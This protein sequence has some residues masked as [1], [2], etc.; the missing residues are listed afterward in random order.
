MDWE[1]STLQP[2]EERAVK[3]RSIAIKQIEKVNAKVDAPASKSYTNRALIIAALA[4][5]KSTL[6]N[7]LVSDDTKFM[8]AA[9]KELGVNIKQEKGKITVKGNGGRFGE[10]KKELFVGNAG[11]AMRFLTGAAALAGGTTTITGNDRMKRRPI[12]DLLDGLRQL[13]V[14]CNSADG[15]PPVKVSGHTLRGGTIKMK[16]NKSS[17]Y[18]TSI[19]MISP[20]AKEDV[21]ISVDGELTSKSYIDITIDVMK[22]FAVGVD[23]NNYKKF[24]VPVGAYKPCDYQIEGDASSA[25]YF[26]G[27]A[28]ITGGK[29]KVN[30][31]NPKSAQGD[32]NFP[33]VLKK[34]GCKVKT[35]KD[36]ISL[37]GGKLKGI[38][39]DMNLMPDT[40]QTLAVVALFAKGKTKIK[41]ISNL[42]IKE[43]DR[44]AALASELKKLGAKVDTK[45]DSITI[46]PAPEYNPAEIETYDDH[47]MAM[48]FSLAG[49]K[50]QGIKIKNPGCVSKSFP[51]YWNKFNEL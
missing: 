42:R 12:E 43:T 34:M 14:V 41:N 40:V 20:Y 17:Q 45:K 38:E 30:N 6:K 46:T 44:I 4:D 33:S 5:G 7:P 1:E 49:L 39:V 23:N 26:F 37:E 35:G 48:S 18:F 27:A 25:S 47:R 24:T 13:G 50:I 19:M 10:A 32:I 28:A 16:G 8:V 51:D 21:V 15:F 31:L 3:M 11:T 29:V 9:L 36:F 22:K 2:N